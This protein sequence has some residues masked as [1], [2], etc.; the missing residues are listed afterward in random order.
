MQLAPAD[1]DQR[2]DGG[3]LVGVLPLPLAGEPA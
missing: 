2:R 1:L 3:R